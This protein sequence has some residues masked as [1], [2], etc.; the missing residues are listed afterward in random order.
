[1]D[2]GVGNVTSVVNACCRVKV[3]PIVTA[4][5]DELLNASPTHILLPGVGAIGEAMGL[6]REYD[7]EVALN[8]LVIRKGVRFLGICVGMQVMAE[9]C[10]EFGEHQG[11]GWIPGKVQRFREKSIRL[12]HIGFN[13]AAASANVSQFFAQVDGDSPDFYFVHSYCFHP[14]DERHIL[15]RTY[16]GSE[17]VSAVGKGRI[18]GVQ[19]HPEKSQSSG[20]RLISDFLKFSAGGDH[21]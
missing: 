16:Y 21:G 9:V 15:A 17:F 14:D 10:E 4:N 7:F 20:L 8:E 3:A 13:A 5:G 12:P 11:L 18:V 19:F 1:M 2:Y 6:L